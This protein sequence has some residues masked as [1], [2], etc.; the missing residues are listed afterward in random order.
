[1]VDASPLMAALDQAGNRRTEPRRAVARL[2]AEQDGH[3]SAADLVVEAQRRRLGLGR[4]TI[5]RTLDLLV[6]VK[7][8][9]RLDLPTGEHAYV[10]CD[11]NHHHHVVC[12][13][14]GRSRDI[15]DLRPTVGE[16][17]DLDRADLA[18]VREMVLR[19]FVTVEPGSAID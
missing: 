18:D 16:R 6:D 11:P 4:A 8:V 7:A 5:F 14:C 15:D 10:A 9:E 17:I 13:G 19:R 3:F 2:I 12:S 1:M